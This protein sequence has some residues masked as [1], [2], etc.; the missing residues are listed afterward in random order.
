MKAGI[1]VRVSTSQQEDGTSPETQEALC[2]LAAEQAG[3]EVESEFIW[4]EQWISIDM[5]RPK[6]NGARQAGRAGL[7]SAL[8]VHTPDRLSREPVHLLMLLNELLESG[9]GLHFVEGISDSTPEGQLLMHVQGYAAQRERA[10]IAEH[11]MRAKEAIAKSGRLPNGTNV[12]LFGYNYDKVEKIRKINEMEAAT[13]RLMFQ[14]AYEGLSSYQI[15]KRLNDQ[16]IRTKKGCYWHSL[17]VKR[18]LKNSAFTGVQYYGENRYRKVSNTKRTVTPRPANEVIR[19]E[20]FSPPIISQELYDAVQERLKVRQCRVSKSDLKYLMT[21]FSTCPKCGSPLVGAAL[22]KGRYRYYRCRAT[23]PTASRPATCDARYIPAD[24]FEDVAWRT[25]AAA[26]RD[27]AVLVSELRDHFA[28][29][30]G[31]PWTGDGVPET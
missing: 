19:I 8:F 5:D 7:I 6:L 16:D 1:Y 26:V 17:G 25:L 29:G 10:Q 4:R 13:V 18:I 22:M 27:P 24:E 9:V 21:G 30:G 20:G 11:S 2:R 15:A 12:G 14:L 3:Y 31:G 23:V 28:T